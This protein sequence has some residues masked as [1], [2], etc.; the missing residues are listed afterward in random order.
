MCSLRKALFLF[1]FCRPF[2]FCLPLFFGLMLFFLRLTYC[3]RTPAAQLQL[4]VVRR[5]R[6]CPRAQP[7]ITLTFRQVE[8]PGHRMCCA[9]V[10]APRPA[11]PPRSAA[12]Y[13]QAA[14]SRCLPV[15]GLGSLAHSDCNSLVLMHLALFVILER[16][17][18]DRPHVAISQS[19]A[20][21]STPATTGDTSGVEGSKKRF[22]ARK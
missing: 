12:R 3:R 20:C 21:T 5:E 17:D 10:P 1:F 19:A 16:D 22:R 18:T 11:V 15:P 13:F 7:Q 2:S 8:S 4:C 6:F 14:P 9:H